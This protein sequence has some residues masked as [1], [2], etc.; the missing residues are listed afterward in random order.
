MDENLDEYR[1]I[2]LAIIRGDPH[3]VKVLRFLADR[4]NDYVTRREAAQAQPEFD[5]NE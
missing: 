5:D 4:Y 2:V 1:D 3:D